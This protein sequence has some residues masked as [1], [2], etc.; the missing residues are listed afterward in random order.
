MNNTNFYK[1]ILLMHILFLGIIPLGYAQN[2]SWVQQRGKKTILKGQI[3]KVFFDDMLTGWVGGVNTNIFHTKDGGINWEELKSENWTTPKSEK[4]TLSEA[5]SN[6]SNC[7]IVGEEGKLLHSND[8][9]KTWKDKSF[10]ED[11]ELSS[12]YFINESIGWI[13]GGYLGDDNLKTSGAVVF[14]TID[15]GQTWVHQ[16]EFQ[17]E[18]DKLSK[19]IFFNT[20]HFSDS[21]NGSIAGA[22]GGYFFKTNDGGKSWGYVIKPVEVDQFCDAIF[23]P[24]IHFCDAS[25]GSYRITICYNS[26][27]YFTTKNG[28]KTWIQQNIQTSEISTK[29]EWYFYDDKNNSQNNF[30]F[31]QN[32]IQ[33]KKQLYFP[34]LNNIY[35]TDTLKGWVVGENGTLLH[36]SDGGKNWEDQKANTKA[37]LFAINFTSSREGW[38][39]GEQGTILSTLDGGKVWKEYKASVKHSLD[40]LFFLNETKGW[41]IGNHVKGTQPVLLVTNNSGQTWEVVKTNFSTTD[42]LKVIYFIDDITGWCTSDSKIFKTSNGGKTWV[43]AKLIYGQNKN[44]KPIVFMDSSLKLNMGKNLFVAEDNGDVWVRVQEYGSHT[45]NYAVIN[46]AVT[47]ESYAEPKTWV[48]GFNGYVGFSVLGVRNFN[49]YPLKTNANLNKLFFINENKG[50]AVGEQGCIYAFNYDSNDEIVNPKEPDNK[51][52]VK[53]KEVNDT[54]NDENTND[55]EPHTEDNQSTIK[56]SK[57]QNFWSSV[58]S[59]FND[60]FYL[61]H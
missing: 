13:G 56:K 6:P 22:H 28:G 29:K 1:R 34:N 24:E 60:L 11:Y 12:V 58:T 30:L 2:S 20:I 55:N 49:K 45:T 52:N 36:T 4:R 57:A 26:E 32:G 27:K 7:W 15:K 21:L 59:F 25:K 51:N 41:I 23:N 38:A 54:P 44:R 10:D 37:S 16:P 53:P 8:S 46:D 5:F 42:E 48:V 3:S 40:N 18:N 33:V 31:H 17:V 9:G 39:V 19:E 50:W 14:K 47:I 61:K 35:F 43:E